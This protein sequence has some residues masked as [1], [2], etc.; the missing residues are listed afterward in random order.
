[1]SA[2]EDEGQIAILHKIAKGWRRSGSNGRAGKSAGG[3]PEVIGAAEGDEVTP[4]VHKHVTRLPH[5]DACTGRERKGAL[6][7][8]KRLY[9][10][11]C[12]LP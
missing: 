2:N 11:E 10:L 7:L 3:E 6:Q 12:F 4:P 1:M 8:V 9:L 5:V